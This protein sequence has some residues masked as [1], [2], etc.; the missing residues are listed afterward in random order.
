[1]R[2]GTELMSRTASAA[3]ISSSS[4]MCQTLHT[5]MDAASSGCMRHVRG[6]AGAAGGLLRALRREDPAS[7]PVGARRDQ[8]G[9]TPLC[10][11][12]GAGYR[13]HVDLRHAEIALSADRL[14]APRLHLCSAACSGA[15]PRAGTRSPTPAPL[16]DPAT[17]AS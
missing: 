10:N 8:G 16:G 3:D 1:M 7:T 14:L 13:L 9:G 4:S 5:R 11:G 15:A 2:S 17:Q 6:G 12:G